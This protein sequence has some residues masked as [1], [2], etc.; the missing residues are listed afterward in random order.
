MKDSRRA[1]ELK[2]RPD[3]ARTSKY[4]KKNIDRLTRQAEAHG[5]RLT[6]T[7]QGEEDNGKKEKEG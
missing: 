2:R 6:I 1:R 5:I 3:K 7:Q 4:Q